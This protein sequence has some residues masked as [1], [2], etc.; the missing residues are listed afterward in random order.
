MQVMIQISI[1]GCGWLG[2]PLAKTLIENKYKVKGSTTSDDKLAV[3]K[4]AGIIPFKIALASDKIDGNMKD[5]LN[6]SDILIID[7]PPKYGKAKKEPFVK[8]IKNRG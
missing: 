5:F 8:K 3:L 2:F 4:N 6:K 7:I 1:L